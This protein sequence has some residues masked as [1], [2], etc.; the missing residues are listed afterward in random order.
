MTD[1][2]VKILKT[3]RGLGRGLS[4]LIADTNSPHALPVRQETSAANAAGSSFYLPLNSLLPGKFQPRNIFNEEELMELAESI[5]KNG[6][7]QPIIVR[8]ITA[9]NNANGTQVYEI[10]AGERRWRAS[11]IA[12][13]EKI[14]AIVMEIDDR[15]ALEIALVENIQRQNLNPVEIAEGY[16]RLVDEFAYTQEELSE[17]IGKSRSQI[18]NFL[19][20]LDLPDDIKNL[21]NKDQITYGHARAILAAPPEAYN[22]IALAI[23][24]KGLNVRQAEKIVKRMS[25]KGRKDRASKR[26][27]DPD[28][29]ELEKVLSEKLGLSVKI[30]N[31]GNKGKVVVSYGSL[32]QLDHIL[33]RL[34]KGA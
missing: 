6:V 11:K 12:G 8:N 10:I 29:I 34:E 13:L 1:S 4:A 23:V 15:Q 19:R 17:V 20:I 30:I 31:K 21:I 33:R 14:P 7:V 32:E 28:I 22:E 25:L 5:K 27:N 16:K 2:K 26:L 9:N 3:G 24:K 18:T